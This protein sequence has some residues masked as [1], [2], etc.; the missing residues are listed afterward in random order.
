MR[1]QILA[2]V[3]TEFNHSGHVFTLT[4][5][6]QVGSSIDSSGRKRLMVEYKQ[7]RLETP[8]SINGLVSSTPNK[9]NTFVWNV[10]DSYVWG[11]VGDVVRTDSPVSWKE[12]NVVLIW[13]VIFGEKKIFASF[14][15]LQETT[16][17]PTPQWF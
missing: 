12:T 16:D 11:F 7:C 8:I 17:A 9:P 10:I 5:V 14:L 13:N 6:T 3:F 15:R 4:G 1:N 2:F